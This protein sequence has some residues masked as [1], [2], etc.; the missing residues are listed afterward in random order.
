MTP[1]TLRRWAKTGVIPGTNG[2]EGWSPAAAATARVVAR[3]RERGH[4]LQ[5]IREAGRQGRLAYGFIEEMFPRRAKGCS[6]AE[7]A[8]EGARGSRAR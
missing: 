5:Q 8:R 7:G 2:S 6:L 3:L 4:S 1:A